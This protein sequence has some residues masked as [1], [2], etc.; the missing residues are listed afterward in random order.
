MWKSLNTIGARSVV[1]FQ[2]T[3]WHLPQLAIPAL[4]QLD[5]AC[6]WRFHDNATIAVAG[7]EP[8]IKFARG[9]ARTL[10]L[11]IPL[12]KSLTR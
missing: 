7:K 10:N 8:K 2:V 4:C 12:F 5:V 1:E 9:G 11:E 3:S 6:V